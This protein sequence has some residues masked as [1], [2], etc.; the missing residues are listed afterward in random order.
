LGRPVLSDAGDLVE[1]TGMAMDVTER[2]LAEEA[3][4]R[5]VEQL[6]ALAE[7]SQNVR[8]EERTRLARE[9]HDELG[10]A[11]TGIKL[12]LRSVID[13]PLPRQAQARTIQAILHSVDETIQ[14]VRK[15]ATD[16]RP[17]VLDDLGLVAAVEWA[18]QDFAARTNA[19]CTMSLPPENMAM[20]PAV[21]TALFRILQEALTNIAR[22]AEATEFS[23]RL[24]EEGDIVC[25]EIRDNGRGFQE[26]QLAP[27][28]TLGVLGMK[29]RALLLGGALTISSSPG[30]GT[31]VTARIHRRGNG[32]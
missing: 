25:L 9:I 1:F 3:L 15:I 17:G 27:V 14:S 19:R 13:R 20:A 21:A 31:T 6:R 26:A 7:K 23:V 30:N 5:S 28:R 8:E 18:A 22:H 2:K 11:L 10:Q 24:D 4:Q 12:D 29:E 32:G 16:L